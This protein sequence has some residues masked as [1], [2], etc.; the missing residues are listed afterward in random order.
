MSQAFAV[1]EDSTPSEIV[2][3]GVGLAGHIGGGLRWS[4]ELAVV[5]TRN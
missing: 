3:V 4:F 1:G 5:N 2:Q